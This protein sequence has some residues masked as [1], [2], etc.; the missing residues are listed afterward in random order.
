MNVQPSSSPILYPNAMETDQTTPNPTAALNP[1]DD[2]ETDQIHPDIVDPNQ[3]PPDPIVGLI[4]NDEKKTRFDI[5]LSKVKILPGLFGIL[6][7]G[8]NSEIESSEVDCTPE[9]LKILVELCNTYDSTNSASWNNLEEKFI[10][11]DLTF[12]DLYGI[13]DRA[14]YYA[15]ST[16][17]EWIKKFIQNER[18]LN[19][20]DSCVLKELWQCAIEDNLSENKDE[21]QNYINDQ[22]HQF[23]LE[24]LLGQRL[25]ISDFED[26]EKILDCYVKNFGLDLLYSLFNDKNE[27]KE[28]LFHLEEGSLYPLIY[29]LMHPK[30]PEEDTKQLEIAFSLLKRFDDLLK[31]F[32][33]S[34]ATGPLQAPYLQPPQLTIQRQILM[35]RMV[36]RMRTSLAMQ[37]GAIPLSMFPAPAQAMPPMPLGLPMGPMPFPVPVQAM[38]PMPLGLPMGPMPFPAPV[39]AMPPM[40]LG[41]AMRQM[42]MAIQQ[43]FQQPPVVSNSSPNFLPFFCSLYCIAKNI[44]N[45]EDFRNLIDLFI[46]QATLSDE[47]TPIIIS[48]NRINFPFKNSGSLVLEGLLILVFENL[49]KKGKKFELLEILKIGVDSIFKLETKQGVVPNLND[50]LG[51][52]NYIALYFLINN[53]SIT[54]HIRVIE[55]LVIFKKQLLE[56]YTDNEIDFTN[57]FLGLSKLSI[58]EV[59]EE[60]TES[61]HQ[62]LLTFAEKYPSEREHFLSAVANH[63]RTCCL[64]SNKQLI[65]EIEEKY[66]DLS[67]HIIIKTLLKPVEESTVNKTQTVKIEINIDEPTQNSIKRILEL[68]EKTNRAK[69]KIKFDDLKQHNKSALIPLLDAIIAHETLGYKVAFGFSKVLDTEL[70]LEAFKHI[71]FALI[72][73]K[74]FD[75][76]F[77]FIAQLERKDDKKI[78]CPFIDGAALIAQ[79]YL[80]EGEFTKSSKYISKAHIEAY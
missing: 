25:L 75:E 62:M 43:P 26:I 33:S 31:N 41:L 9:I 29:L 3:T 58:P 20:L 77:D 73:Q 60:E 61:V 39:Q 7:G 74:K 57:L 16:V 35:Q 1:A 2:R 34:P 78:I 19:S 40:P 36:Q 72:K 47:F 56:I 45:P 18:F 71:F 28:F 14:N 15:S 38:P 54:L 13:Y 63:Y 42:Q 44:E 24:F 37:S 53:S 46:S 80:N 76:F 59:N 49:T 21:S 27:R 17:M 4:A 67:N 12:N 64:L 6:N 11:Q 23:V 32:N 22:Y 69:A 65:A 51:S 50:L 30:V 68:L 79:L 5:S 8:I 52:F 66:F 70:K 55:I 48:M 10:N